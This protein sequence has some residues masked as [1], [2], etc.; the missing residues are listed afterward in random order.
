LSA[1]IATVCSALLETAL[2][3]SKKALSTFVPAVTTAQR[4]GST[5][6]QLASLGMGLYGVALLSVPASLITG[7]VVIITALELR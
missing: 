4:N 5:L 2:A 1:A 7:A 6:A 3:F